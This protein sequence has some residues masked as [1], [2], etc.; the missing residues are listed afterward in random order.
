MP[1][2]TLEDLQE[3]L[4]RLQAQVEPSIRDEN[5]P[6]SINAAVTAPLR[7]PPTTPVSRDD[8][9]TKNVISRLDDRIAEATT[10]E[11]LELLYVRDQLITQEEAQADRKHVRAFE[12]KN[13]YAKVGL[14]FCAFAGGVGLVATGFGLPGF[15]C[16]GAGL[17]AI[18]PSFIDRVTDRVIGKKKP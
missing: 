10:R 13:F 5:L 3:Q 12:G 18:A 7:A 15:V 1:E 17:Y 4:K 8:A 6:S 11:M 9:Q 14:S 16:I 2:P